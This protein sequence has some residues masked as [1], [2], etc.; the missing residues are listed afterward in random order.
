VTAQF[1]GSKG[2]FYTVWLKYFAFIA[3]V[4][5]VFVAVIGIFAA[6]GAGGLI[7][8]FKTGQAAAITTALLFAV[9][10]VI[11]YI[12]FLSLT[13]AYMNSRLQNLVWNKTEGATPANHTALQFHSDL[14]L[15]SLTKVMAWNVFLTLVT[16][17]LYWPFAAIKFAKVRLESVS[18]TQH[19][20]WASIAPSM[21]AATT[22]GALGSEAQDVFDVD[23][24]L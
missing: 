22:D 3:G 18:V 11:A 24:A 19:L 6:L 13:Q 15:W 20:P 14:L 17:G 8:S 4:G 10:G 12:L 5:F 16:L 21:L 7:M 23:F 2:N 1:T 9:L